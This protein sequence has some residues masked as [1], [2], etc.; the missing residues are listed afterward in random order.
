MAKGKPQAKIRKPPIEG[1]TSNIA[2]FIGEGDTRTNAPKVQTSSTP[3]VQKSEEKERRQT[4]VYFDQDVF[5]QLK[6]HC[7]MEDAEMSATVTEA[8][9]RYLELP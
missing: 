8:V 1:E 2:A 4:T 5:K 9:R 6:V 3:D 7:V